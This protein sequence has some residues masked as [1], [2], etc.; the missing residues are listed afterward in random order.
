M[1]SKIRMDSKI[2]KF[3]GAGNVTG[4]VGQFQ[5]GGG[6][7]LTVHIES[8]LAGVLRVLNKKLSK[9]NLIYTWVIKGFIYHNFKLIFI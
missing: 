1:D 9:V 5:H 2:K 6:L 8:V 4:T 3:D 7:K